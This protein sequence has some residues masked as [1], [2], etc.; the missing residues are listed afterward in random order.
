V[1]SKVLVLQGLALIQVA[2]LLLLVDWLGPPRQLGAAGHAVVLGGI[3]GSYALALAN[4]YLTALGGIGL[5]LVISSLAG[6]SD[7]AMSM[8]PIALLPQILFAGALTVPRSGTLTRIAGYLVGVNWSFDLFRREIACTPEELWSK[9]A[10]ECLAAFDPH[11]S[12]D[13][14]GHL[15]APGREVVMLIKDGLYSIPGDLIVLGSMALLLLALVVAL[16]WRKR[17]V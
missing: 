11:Q 8:V 4:L 6:N 5:G 17:P 2:L 10:P 12:G 14:M 9:H 15:K 1:L 3:P 7:K 13:V 16:Q